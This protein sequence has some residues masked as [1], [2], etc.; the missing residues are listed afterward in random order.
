MTRKIHLPLPACASESKIK[1]SSRLNRSG[2]RNVFMLC[3]VLKTAPIFGRSLAN[4]SK[5]PNKIDDAFPN[6]T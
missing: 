2:K 3:V 6:K 1:R 4:S 5:I